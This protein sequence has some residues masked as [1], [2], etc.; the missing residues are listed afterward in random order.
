MTSYSPYT[1]A[2]Q[3]HAKLISISPLPD[4]KNTHTSLAEFSNYAELCIF[5]YAWSTAEEERPAMRVSERVPL[6]ADL[7]QLLVTPC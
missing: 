2:E 6:T 5:E 4:T 1:E 3:K 7:A